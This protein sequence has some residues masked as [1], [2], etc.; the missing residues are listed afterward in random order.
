MQTHHAAGLDLGKFRRCS[1]FF[2]I[3]NSKLKMGNIFKTLE[4]L[5]NYARPYLQK[6]AVGASLAGV[7]AKLE[8][9]PQVTS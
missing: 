6:M 2:Y 3:S 4:T 8:V 7:R 5:E 9:V 1:I